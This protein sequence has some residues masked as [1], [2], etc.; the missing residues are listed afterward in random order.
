VVVSSLA[1]AYVW[2][3]CRCESLGRELKVLEQRQSELKK[4]YDTEAFKWARKKSPRN[5]E[6]TL[7][8]R[9]ITMV[10]PHRTRVVR[11]LEDDLNGGLSGDAAADV[12]KYARLDRVTGHE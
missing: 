7:E 9:R 4:H 8:R 5:I 12:H 10:W 3:G 11:L 1:L 2:L 6:R